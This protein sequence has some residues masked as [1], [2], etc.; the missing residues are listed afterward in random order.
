M[1]SKFGFNDGDSVPAEAEA[2]R[3]VY[4][5]VLNRLLERFNS[6]YRVVPYG[7]QGVHNWVLIVNVPKDY[8]EALTPEERLIGD[9]A[10]AAMTDDEDDGFSEAMQHIVELDIDDCVDVT[11]TIDRNKLDALLEAPQ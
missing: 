2:C 6:A 11:V 1:T 5:I 10:N 4:C 7:R 8:Y 3:E 9:S